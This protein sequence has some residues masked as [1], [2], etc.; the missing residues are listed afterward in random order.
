[1]LVGSES[2]EEETGAGEPPELDGSD[3][4]ASGRLL[5]LLDRFDDLAGPGHRHDAQELHPLHMSHHCNT[6]G[7]HPHTLPPLRVSRCHR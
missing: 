7:R 3:R 4:A 6:H 2:R 5:P 1:M